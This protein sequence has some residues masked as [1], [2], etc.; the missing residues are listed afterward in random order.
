MPV[1][2]GAGL[3]GDPSI[4]RAVAAGLVEQVDGNANPDDGPDHHACNPLGVY[5]RIVGVLGVHNDVV[6]LLG[7]QLVHGLDP[8]V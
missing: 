2:A 7:C 8:C 4:G 5:L 6:E 3:N 1:N